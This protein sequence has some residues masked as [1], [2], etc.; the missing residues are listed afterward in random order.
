MIPRAYYDGIKQKIPS[1][2][3]VRSDGT[4]FELI[5]NILLFIF[6]GYTFFTH[7]LEA[8]VPAK[9]ANNPYALQPDVWPKAII[10]LLEICLIVNIIQIIKK[11]KG[12]PEFTLGAFVGSIPA[13]LKSKL[14][15]GIVIMVVASFILDT[16]GFIVTSLFILFF[17]GLLIGEKKHRP[18]ADRVRLHH[19]G[20]LH[21][22]QRHAQRQPAARH[23][24]LLAQLRAVA[25]IHRGRGQEHLLRR[26]QRYEFG[27]T[28]C[29][30]AAAVFNPGMFLMV[31]VAI[32][33]GTIFGALPGV[34]ATMAVALGLTFTYTME[35]IPAIVFLVA[36]YC[37]SITGG[38]ITAILFKIPGVPSS[39][40]TTF[41]GYP[42][43]QRGEAGKALGVALLASAIGGLFS[44]IAMFL[45]SQPLTKAALQFGPS[46]LF[47]VTFMGLSIL[48]CLDSDH[49]LNC[50][51]SGLIGLL[52]ACVGQDKMYAVQRLTFGSRNLLAGI[53]MIPVLIG[54][55]A[56]T[57]VFKQTDPKKKRLSAED[58]ISGG[59]VST[60]MP[61]FKEIWSIK[62]TMLRCSVIG[63]IVGILPGA[64]ATIASFMCY[65]METKFSSIRKNSAPVSS[66]ALR[67]PK[68]RTTPRPAARWFPLL[69][70][71]IPG[72]NAAAVM[73]SA[74]TLKGVQLGPLL[75]T[76][77]PT[78]LSA[79]FMSMIVTNILMVIVAM[80]IAKVFAQILAIPYSYLGPIIMM[81][82]LIGT[83]GDQMS[84]TSV[85]I[86]V[87]AGILGLVV[88]ACHL[89]SAAIVL[90]LVLGSMCEQNF[91]RGYLMARARTS[92]RCSTRRCIRSPSC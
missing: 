2:G 22:L 24:R 88:R 81:L 37:S 65:T 44:A 7:V 46:D 36:I 55:F 31:C 18:P 59:K 42:M 64:G 52:L 23:G 11:N 13:F 4:V 91:S 84:A 34:S 26:R 21:R 6:F 29:L 70:L 45:L 51:I 85:Q 25:R 38:S 71:G 1:A 83:Y 32:I 67:L 9:V 48:T 90:G 75:L 49:I 8:A 53:D 47:A 43:A 50:I 78:Y 89:N 33:L 74:L 87:L 41:D 56:V 69:S 27:S 86:M 68:R 92:S 82:A 73:M 61:S 57:E 16:V 63:T 17:Y 3:G 14:F 76:N 79:T 10:I 54:L 80:A 35:P 28:S 39:A 12:N 77:Q 60:K 5:I 20:A 72:G 30:R 58:G 15:F 40:P 66:T 62:W 19:D